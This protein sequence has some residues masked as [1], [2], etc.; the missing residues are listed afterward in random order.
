ME[1]LHLGSELTSQLR[2]VG[3]AYLAGAGSLQ[4]TL[5]VAEQA[6]PPITPHLYAREKQDQADQDSEQRIDN[7]AE[8]QVGTR[9]LPG[10][11]EHPSDQ[12]KG[13]QGRR[14][15]EE[16]EPHGGARPALG[17]RPPRRGPTT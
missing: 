15:E 5:Q 9:N 6:E 13:E 3:G 10:P 12:P 14:D 4:S 8:Y 7:M 16:G 11:V 1:P 2:L 17:G